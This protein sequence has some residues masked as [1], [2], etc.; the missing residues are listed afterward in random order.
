MLPD[1]AVRFRGVAGF[2]HDF[3]VRVRRQ[4]AAQ[5]GSRQAF[6]VNDDGTQTCIHVY[7]FRLCRH[8]RAGQSQSRRD[9]AVA[10]KQVDPGIDAKD[11]G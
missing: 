6:V 7:F 5:F 10:L 4:Q 3:H 11:Q 8:R 2:G 9:P 1:Q